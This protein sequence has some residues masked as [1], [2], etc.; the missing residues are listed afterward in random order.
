LHSF[1]ISTIRFFLLVVFLS[2]PPF[3]IFIDLFLKV[4]AR[5]RGCGGWQPGPEIIWLLLRHEASRGHC[6]HHRLCSDQTIPLT[7]LGLHGYL[8]IRIPFV[9]F[10]VSCYVPKG[11]C[12]MLSIRGLCAVSSVASYLV[13]TIGQNKRKC[14]LKFILYGFVWDEYEFV[15]LAIAFSSRCASMRVTTPVLSRK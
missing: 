7:L 11:A 9:T 2:V 12:P 6:D 13:N 4:C 10:P 14:K 8:R 5:Y 1:R 3:L 15:C